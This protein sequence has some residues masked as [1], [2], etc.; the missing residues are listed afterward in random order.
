MPHDPLTLLNDIREAAEFILE[1]TRGR[2]LAEYETDRVVNAAVER[3]F[4]TLGEALGRLVRVDERFASAL[5][6]YPQ[7]IGLRNVV[8]HGYDIIEHSTFGVSSRMRFR[9]C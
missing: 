2:S 1:Q 7:I 5:G 4:I 9:A 8:V 6:D 3:H